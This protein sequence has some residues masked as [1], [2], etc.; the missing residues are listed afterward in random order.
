MGKKIPEVPDHDFQED[1]SC[2]KIKLQGCLLPFLN[3]ILL[4]FN[5]VRVLF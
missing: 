3:P 4:F 1:R 5:G 2:S